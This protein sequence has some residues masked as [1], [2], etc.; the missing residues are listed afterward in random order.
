MTS[1]IVLTERIKVEFD[2]RGKFNYT[3]LESNETYTFERGEI[4]FVRY[5][6][7]KYGMAEIAYIK[8]S[9]KKFNHS[10]HL[11]EVSL[12]E[13]S[14]KEIEL[15]SSLAE[16]AIFLYID[17]HKDNIL[18]KNLDEANKKL[19]EPIKS[20]CL[21]KVERVMLKDKDNML[22]MLVTRPIIKNIS[23][24]LG[25][26]ENKIGF[27]S[28]AFSIDGMCCL[29]AERARD[30]AARYSNNKSFAIATNAVEGRNIEYQPG[31]CCIKHIIISHDIDGVKEIVTEMDTFMK[32]NEFG[33]IETIKKNENNKKCKES[34]ILNKFPEDYKVDGQLSFTKDGEILEEKSESK[35]VE[36][37]KKKKLKIPKNAI[38]F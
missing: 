6:F 28:C 22:H 8:E 34:K 1:S 13:T 29:T 37:K 10:A 14:V 25:L 17:L 18:A 33:D 35:K 7:S 38:K 20:H 16:V 27:C 5:R 12:S 23:V 9:L 11:A 19:L 30:I 31:C 3:D 32:P 26:N 2:K 36:S 15:L 24:Y 4:P 21:D